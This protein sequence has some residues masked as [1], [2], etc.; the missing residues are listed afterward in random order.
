[1]EKEQLL[2]ERPPKKE[3]D[4]DKIVFL[5]CIIHIDQ[6]REGKDQRSA[7]AAEPPPLEDHTLAEILSEAG[8]FCEERGKSGIVLNVKEVGCGT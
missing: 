4:T 6:D 1:M 8:M 2:P 5:L 7:P 3:L